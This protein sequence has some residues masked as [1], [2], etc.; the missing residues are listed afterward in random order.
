VTGV[1][2]VTGV[3]M[4]FVSVG[5]TAFVSLMIALGVLLDIARRGTDPASPE[6]REQFRTRRHPS[7]HASPRPR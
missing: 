5:G 3:P 1:A 2:P 4:P 7:Q 6:R